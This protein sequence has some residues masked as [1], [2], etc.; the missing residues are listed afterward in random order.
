VA[1]SDP[2][3]LIKSSEENR[4]ISKKAGKRE[5]NKQKPIIN[6]RELKRPL[7]GWRE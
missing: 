7:N 4:K 6:Y 2:Y 5:N 1:G 3:F